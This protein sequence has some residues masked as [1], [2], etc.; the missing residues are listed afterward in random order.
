[1]FLLIYNMKG[2]VEV[3]E[4]NHFK[5]QDTQPSSHKCPIIFRAKKVARIKLDL[6]TVTFFSPRGNSESL[7]TK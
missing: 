6:V 2:L 3:A 7:L 1:M 5:W 4:S